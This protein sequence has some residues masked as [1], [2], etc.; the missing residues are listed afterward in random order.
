MIDIFFSNSLL[1]CH[2]LSVI[3][4]NLL[5]NELNKKLA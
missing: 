1:L 5:K 4:L 2:D 3:A